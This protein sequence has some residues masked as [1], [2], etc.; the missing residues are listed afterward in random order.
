LLGEERGLVLH[1]LEKNKGYI[2]LLRKELMSN[3][4]TIHL[5]IE[6][7]P[8]GEYLATCDD[9]PGLVAQGCTISE[10]VEIAQDVAKKLIESYVEH[11]D[12]LPDTLK[13]I[14]DEVELD[15]AVG[16]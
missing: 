8:E 9:L 3:E 4:Y 2:I 15:I 1:L 10:A 11:G 6:H 13:K 5:K 14:A 16:A 7:L 12:K